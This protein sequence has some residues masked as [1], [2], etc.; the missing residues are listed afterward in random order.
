MR[1]PI[2]AILAAGTVA[3]IWHSTSAC[4]PRV[5][6]PSG[7]LIDHGSAID[8]NTWESVS[9]DAPWDDFKGGLTV[10]FSLPDFQT[11][12]VV[13]VEPYVA[14]ATNVNDGVEDFTLG[15]GD[16]TEVLAAKDGYVRI[17]NGTCANL[18][19]R[20]VV[21]FAPISD[22]DA[23]APLDA[24]ADS[25]VLDGSPSADAGTD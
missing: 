18:H 2:W 3:T 12:R 25:S 4:Q 17:R 16:I 15:S 1:N 23:S 11:R 14:F 7:A 19:I 10:Q 22:I 9:L 24:T 20:V 8:A 5:C 21:R 6:D 13:S